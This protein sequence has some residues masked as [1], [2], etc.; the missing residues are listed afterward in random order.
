VT[1]CA[2][3]VVD[4]LAGVVVGTTALE[5]RVPASDVIV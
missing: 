5:Q 4:L 1:A 2:G 3:P